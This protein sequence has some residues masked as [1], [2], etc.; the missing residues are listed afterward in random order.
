M[1]DDRKGIGI[2]RF[3]FGSVE[4]SVFYAALLIFPGYFA[5]VDTCDIIYFNSMA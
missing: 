4:L 2:Q 5:R 3:Y 1:V